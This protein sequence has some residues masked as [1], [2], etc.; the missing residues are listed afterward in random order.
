MTT[1]L[2]IAGFLL[3]ATP[4]LAATLPPDIA[5][6]V[7]EYDLAQAHNDIP[8]LDRL[9]AD[10]F[11]LVNSNGTIENKRQY[12]ADFNFPGFKIN[13]YV[14]EQ[15]IEKVWGDAAMVGGLLHLR[16]TQDGKRQ[17]RTLRI[18]YVWARHGGR[19]RTTYAQ[20]TRVPL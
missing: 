16:W 10:D 18:A 19:W 2:A 17:S 5:K 14:L 13:P 8:I 1:K 3:S 6:A 11:V 7:E 4:G 9:V 12:L 20:V 15:R